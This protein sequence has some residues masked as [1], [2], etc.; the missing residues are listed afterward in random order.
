MS[1]VGDVTIEPLPAN[2]VQPCPH[3]SD[4]VSRGGTVADDEITIGRLGDALIDC[5][6]AK[7]IAVDAYGGVQ[8]ILGAE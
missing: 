8:S 2:V 1:R 3:P 6:E 4:L 7:D 5:G